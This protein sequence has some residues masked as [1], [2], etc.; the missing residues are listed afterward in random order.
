MTP[1]ELVDADPESLRYRKLVLDDDGRAI[2]AILLGHPEHVQA[3]TAAVR[4]SRAM[5]GWS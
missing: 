1:R 4:E 3:V 2:G 5:N